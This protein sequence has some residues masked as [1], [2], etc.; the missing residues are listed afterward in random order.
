LMLSAAA[1]SFPL[2]S[3]SSRGAYTAITPEYADFAVPHTPIPSGLKP[4][5]S[6]SRPS[7]EDEESISS[8]RH[9]WLDSAK[10]FLQKNTGLLLFIASQAF[11]TS[12]NL[13]VKILNSIDPPITP[14][15]L[16]AVRMAITYL[17]CLAYM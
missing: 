10:D 1:A 9:G 3:M 2:A 5:S 13:S 12:M 15:E 8:Q 14:L 4:S 17:C 7:V 16:I 6:R 11:I